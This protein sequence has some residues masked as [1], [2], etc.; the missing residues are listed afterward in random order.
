MVEFWYGFDRKCCTVK[1][2]RNKG[3]DFFQMHLPTIVSLDM[4]A[5]SIVSS[6]RVSDKGGRMD[7]EEKRK[8]AR[9]KRFIACLDTETERIQ[10]TPMMH[11]QTVLAEHIRGD[12]KLWSFPRYS[13]RRLLNCDQPFVRLTL[14]C[15][16][17]T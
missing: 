3:V 1:T 11:M 13:I 15:K 9:L 5:D 7:D 4:I 8:R 14:A 17:S 10:K 12:V 2:V 16:I 6:M